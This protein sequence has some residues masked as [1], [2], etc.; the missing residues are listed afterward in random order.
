M[1]LYQGRPQRGQSLELVNKGLYWWQMVSV[2]LLEAVI[3]GLVNPAAITLLPSYP[4]NGSIQL[5]G[6]CSIQ[7]LLNISED[8]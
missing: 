5:G 7:I 8:C 3:E 6:L 1:G 4:R 2:T